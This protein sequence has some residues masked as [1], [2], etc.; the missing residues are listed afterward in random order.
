MAR[1]QVPDVI[2][3][4]ILVRSRRRC[5]IC[6]GLESDLETKEGQVAHLDRNNTN[7]DFDNLAFLCLRHHDQYDSKTSQSKGLRE[8]E[9]KRYRKEL[10]DRI[11]SG[12]LDDTKSKAAKNHQSSTVNIT[13]S[14]NISPSF[15]QASSSTS[16]PR[17]EKRAEEILPNVG[18]LRPEIW[19][20]ILDDES[21]VW[22][23]SSRME[24]WPDEFLTVVLPFSNDPQPGRKTLRLDGL[25]A[26]LTYYKR[27]S[28]P[29][30]KRIDAGCWIGEGSPY[31]NLE[32]GGIVYL[33]AAILRNERTNVLENLRRG[34]DQGSISPD[35]IPNS[36]YELKVTLMA[37]SHGEYSEKYWFELEVG[38]Q[39]KCKRM[40]KMR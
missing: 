8:G 31:I 2:Q 27:D 12:L 33:I 34:F 20:T 25:K 38:E 4:Q 6:F 26:R 32:V 21:E 24:P 10:Y 11:V 16:T 9:V 35:G 40:G 7:Y 19:R 17:E 29:E 5:C 37:G 15:T 36:T 3:N 30:F 13:V 39:L 14:P 28:I 1:N 18:H 23:K 22:E